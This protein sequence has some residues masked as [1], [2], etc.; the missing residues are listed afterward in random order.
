MIRVANNLFSCCQKTYNSVNNSNQI[1]ESEFPL[2]FK[3]PAGCDKD[4]CSWYFAMG[5]N[6]FNEDFL[7][8]Y[9]EASAGGWVAV[10]FSLNQE[11]V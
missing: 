1:A 5:P 3:Y 7:D 8:I 9:M 6:T 2:T 10:G 11:M 4:E